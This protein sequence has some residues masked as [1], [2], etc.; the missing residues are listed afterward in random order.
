M[1]SLRISYSDVSY[2][3]GK[4]IY[5]HNGED[6]GSGAFELKEKAEIRILLPR[7]VGVVSVLAKVYD[8][9][10]SPIT[11]KRCELH[12]FDYQS[13]SY[14]FFPNDLGVGLYYV[15]FELTCAV[16]TL[17]VYRGRKNIIVLSDTDRGECFQFSKVDFSYSAPDKYYG[18]IIY[19]IFV[20]RFNRGGSIKPREDAVIIEDWEGATP[21]Y[22]EYPGA[23][24]ENNTFF[25]GT[26]YGIIEKLDYIKSLGTTL[27]YLSPIFEAYSNHKY[28]TGDYMKVDDMFGGDEALKLLISE[29]D[30]RGIGIILDGVFNHTGNDSVYFNAKGRYP[31]I[32]AYQSKNSPFYKWYDFQSF[33]NKYTCWWGIKILPRINPDIPECGEFIVGDGGVIEK[34]AKMGIAGFRLDVADELSDKFIASIKGRLQ[35]YIPESI[36]YGEVWED[37]SNK[38]AYEKRKHYYLGRELDGVMNYPLRTGIISYI[39]DKRCDALEYALTDIIFNA[40]KRIRDMQMNLLGTHDTERIITILAGDTADGKTNET[41]SQTF[42]TDEQR[43]KGIKMLKAAYTVLSTVPGIPTVFYGDEAGLE[44]YKDPFNR[45]PYPWQGADIELRDFFVKIGR[46][47]TSNSAFRD[48][49]F[50]LIRLDSDLLIFERNKGNAHYYTVVNNSD[51][52]ARLSLSEIS[53]FLISA[54]KCDEAILKAGTAEIIY[55]NRKSNIKVDFIQKVRLN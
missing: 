24:L 11:E 51:S 32:G 17:Y 37:A 40:P 53:E 52:D 43:E 54:K 42:L 16:G 26:L 31:S 27:I 45:R 7:Q 47:R 5:L 4:A 50:N 33:P 3:S 25:G 29:A 19:H 23:H 14:S 2:L 12:S 18:G 10:F 15:Y 30:A 9:S 22:P 21:E 1:N 13:E 55:S 48:A 36:S 38:V 6:I 46:I 49:D 41:L 39:R 35:Q 28:D 8:E 34:Y 20:D 44:G